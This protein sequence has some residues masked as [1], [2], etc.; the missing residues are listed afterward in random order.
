[1]R[2]VPV[3][4]I[5]LTGCAFEATIRGT[6][7]RPPPCGCDVD[8]VEPDTE[9]EIDVPACP[10][11]IVYTA[12]DSYVVDIGESECDVRVHL[13]GAGGGGGTAP[14]GGGAFAVVEVDPPATLA[15]V[16]GG[17][18]GGGLPP[19]GAGGGGG[20]SWA[21]IPQVRYIGVAGGGG[22][23]GGTAGL[24]GQSG[25]CCVSAGD[26]APPNALGGAGGFGPSAVGGTG[27]L[28]GGGGGGSPGAPSGGGATGGAGGGS[29][30]EAGTVDNGEGQQPA[31]STQSDGSGWGGDAF[32]MGA[33]GRVEIRFTAPSLE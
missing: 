19:D 13:W 14:G 32:S 2:L 1:M 17:G 21:A 25:G 9:P 23:G 27:G 24:P 3:V 11:S 15:L 33:P 18:G 12:P 5:L 7:T 31:R 16:V 6:C 28:A 30:T 29:I 20:A 10:D 4:F 26:S 8:C 22:G